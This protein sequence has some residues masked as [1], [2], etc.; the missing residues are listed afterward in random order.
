MLPNL[1]CIKG[2]TINLA[3][4][5]VTTTSGE[6]FTGE[7]HRELAR[8]VYQRFGYDLAAAVAAWGRLLQNS[9]SYQDFAELA[10]VTDAE[11]QKGM[12]KIRKT[13]KAACAKAER[14]CYAARA[15]V[16]KRLPG[17]DDVE[18][19]AR[20]NAVKRVDAVRD[21]EVEAARA[22][23]SADMAT[24]RKWAGPWAD[25]VQI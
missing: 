20:G 19:A 15:E 21:A 23:R 17:I 22:K 10:G 16:Y 24:L 9:C 4:L 18:R 13:Y 25:L 5:T 3:N 12:E 11:V 8:L 2:M 6:P 7:Q 14:K 1:G